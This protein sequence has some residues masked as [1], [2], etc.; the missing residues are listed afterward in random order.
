M[1]EGWRRGGPLSRV[2]PPA[3]PRRA[4]SVCDSLDLQDVPAVQAA[5]KAAE[6]QKRRPKSF[7]A[8]G[9]GLSSAAGSPSRPSESPARPRVGWLELLGLRSP[10]R[11][12]GA[13]AGKGPTDFPAGEEEGGGAGGF[14]RGGSLWGSRRRWKLFDGSAPRRLSNLRKSFSFRLRRGGNE[15]QRAGSGFLRPTRLRSRSEGDAA[16][17]YPCPSKRD[18]LGS[19]GSER[20]GGGGGGFWKQLGSRLRRRERLAGRPLAPGLETRGGTAL[21]WSRRGAEPVLMAHRRPGKKLGAGG[22]LREG[23]WGLQQATSGKPTPRKRASPAPQHLERVPSW[24]PPSHS[25]DGCGSVSASP[26]PPPGPA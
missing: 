21:L 3:A 22:G 24:L 14:L 13:D 16:Y 8:P 12:D 18:L 9:N 11:S 15:L 26:A 10:R 6:K 25:A 1:A 5:L 17:L 20:G 7:C 4:V 23:R 2:T 19:T